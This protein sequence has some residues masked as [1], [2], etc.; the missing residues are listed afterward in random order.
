MNIGDR[1][2]KARTA[3]GLSQKEVALSIE[4]DQSQYSKIERGL[5]DPSISTVERIIKAIGLDWNEFFQPDSLPQEVNSHQKS[6]ME[7]LRLIEMLD[8]HEQGSIFTILAAFVSKKKLTN[9]LE[10]VLKEAQ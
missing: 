5:T 7:R 9:A 10:H 2:R 6:L 3:Q 8:E 4:M 1:I